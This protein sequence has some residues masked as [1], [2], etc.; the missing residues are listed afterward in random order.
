M[1]AAAFETIQPPGPITGLPFHLVQTASR[2][3][4][5]LM[6]A[7]AL[8]AALAA[9][10]PFWFIAHHAVRDS[11]LLTERPDTSVLLAAALIAWALLFGWPIVRR[12]VRFGRQRHVAIS[13]D[14][15]TVTEG[16]GSW[17]KTWS[18]PLNAY[19]GLAHHIRASLSGT[20]HELILIHPEP[21]R[22]LLLR[23]D[24]KITQ[25][26]I[27]RLATLLGC[28][29]IAPQLFYRKRDRAVGARPVML[30]PK[31]AVAG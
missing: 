21:M 17:A 18:E 26:E 19:D 27:D 8:P 15:V 25:A 3:S 31:L 4:P 6:L 11:T 16:T 22:C 10:T 9:L 12:A 14:H 29:E 13:A 5:V 24:D 28:R 23:A 2:T 20:R 30:Q 1:R 7:L